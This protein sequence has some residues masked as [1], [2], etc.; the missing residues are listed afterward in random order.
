M[1]K[2]ECIKWVESHME[3]RY[4]T[5]NGAYK[6]KR[7]INPQGAVN[8]SVGCAQPNPEVFYRNMNKT[9]CGWGVMAIIGGFNT[10]DG[11]IIV[12]LP[13][14]A[15]NWG[16]GSGSKGSWNNTK[17]QWEIC[18]PP[19]HTYAGGTMVNYNVT[20]NQEYFNRMWKMIVAW[21]V[22]MCDKFGYSVANI[23]DHAESHKAGMGSNHSDVGQWW[24]KHGKSM[25]A[26]RAE[27]QAIMN[28][29]NSGTCVT[30]KVPYK[31]KTTENLNCRKEAAVKTGNVIKTYP[32]GI[33][34]NITKV[35][36]GWGYTGEGWVSLAYTIEYV[37]SAEKD[38]LK[39]TEAELNKLID[40]RIA[41]HNASYA[42]VKD[43]PACWRQTIQ[44][45]LDMDLINGGTPKNVNPTDVNLSSDTIKA[46][47]IMKGYI[48]KIL[49][50][51]K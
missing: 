13:Y 7:F 4:A 44:S 11:K 35:D 16:C 26:L 48:D 29:G 37:N 43:V 46:L 2:Q 50:S 10:G 8:H 3:I 28:G 6:A 41:Q 20:K 1:T 42:D 24:P 32:K 34:L 40:A 18:E 33:I 27:V 49:G 51:K 19:G 22:Y 36:N 9:S 23:S 25:A 21:N 47:V 38:V 31:A 17:I 30:T 45:F 5:N 14:N 12:C 39:M 15:R